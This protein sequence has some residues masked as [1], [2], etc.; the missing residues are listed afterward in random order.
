M[1]LQ[2]VLRTIL[3]DL[4]SCLIAIQEPAEDAFAYWSALSRGD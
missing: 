2:A 4:S 3:P 1:N